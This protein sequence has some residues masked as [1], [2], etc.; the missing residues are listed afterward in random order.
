MSKIFITFILSF[1]C[2]VNAHQGQF[3]PTK[4][5]VRGS[6]L[7]SAKSTST[8]LTLQSIIKDKHGAFNKVIISGTLLKI[9]E[10]IM[11]YQV[12][13]INA[14]SVVIKSPDRERTLTLLPQAIVNY[15]NK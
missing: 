7:P 3:D 15:K 12:V 1:A 11:N 4:P 2:S 5:L 10:P 14:N 9:G 6:D 13:A 8:D